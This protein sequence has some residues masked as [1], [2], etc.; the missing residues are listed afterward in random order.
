LLLREEI[1][2]NLIIQLFIFTFGVEE[3]RTN[4]N[5]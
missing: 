4:L 3:T 2:A 1:L 5:K